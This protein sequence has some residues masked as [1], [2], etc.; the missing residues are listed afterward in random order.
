MKKSTLKKLI[1]RQKL[2]EKISS[3]KREEL[4][5]RDQL[6]E[7]LNININRSGTQWIKLKNGSK[8]RITIAETCEVVEDKLPKN[9]KLLKQIISWRPVLKKAEFNKLS[10]S[11]RI[12]FEDSI[13]FKPVKP[14][15]DL[16][17][18]LNET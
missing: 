1:H 17:E 6:L 12:L 15:M 16:L 10:R 7:E 18:V 5:L 2:L 14:Q 4:E 3:L 9:K 13:F 11:D 8:I